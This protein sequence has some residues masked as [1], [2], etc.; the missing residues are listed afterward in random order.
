MHAYRSW[1]PLVDARIQKRSIL[2]SHHWPIWDELA[3][4]VKAAA[5][6]AEKDN[7]SSLGVKRCV[8]KFS[9]SG[10]AKCFKLGEIW[11]QQ[12]CKICMKMCE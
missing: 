9:L 2:I 10:L 1:P 4:Q 6:A 12:I 3:D 7:S 11:V 8:D 5:A